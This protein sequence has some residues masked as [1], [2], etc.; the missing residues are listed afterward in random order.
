MIRTALE[1]IRKELDA[2]IVDREQDPGNYALNNVVDLKPVYLPDG[3]YN[4]NN[5]MHITMMLIGVDEERREGKRPYYVPI[6]NKQFMKLNPPIELDLSI[7]FI[8]QS[9]NYQ[10]ALRDL[11]DVVAFF[12]VYNVFDESK[13]PALNA[14]VSDPVNKPWQL[15]ER[16]SFRLT[17]LTFEQQNNL[18]ATLGGKYIPSV[19]YKANMLT[20]FDT[21]GKEA[22]PAITEMNFAD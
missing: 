5:A 21:R 20:V 18:W 14:D 3:T 6:E 11:S 19:V 1:F 4:L 17:S 7:L 15:I 2:Y 9:T 8:A 10:T 13:F 22:A 16:L 12:Q